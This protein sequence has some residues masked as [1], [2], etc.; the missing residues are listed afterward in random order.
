M[1][2]RIREWREKRGLTQEEMAEKLGVHFTTYS[3]VE[4]GHT[5]LSEQWIKRLC[6][7][8]EV[9]PADLIGDDFEGPPP[10]PME[11]MEECVLFTPGPDHWLAGTDLKEKQRLYVIKSKAIDAI[12]IKDGAIVIC[13]FDT[14]RIAN[15]MSGNSPAPVIVM[16]HH[17]ATDYTKYVLLPRQFIPPHTI[18]RNSSDFEVSPVTLQS[19]RATI[20]AVITSV[21]QDI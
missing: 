12:H 1:R 7:A 6:K 4:N 21:I 20:T 3:R 18:I 9:H 16:F 8:L 17:D 5:G 10:A 14:D 11:F 2:N 15:I 19:G 13:D